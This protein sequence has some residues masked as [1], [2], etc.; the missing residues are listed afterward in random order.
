MWKWSLLFAL[1]AVLSVVVGTPFALN[2][3]VTVVLV[4]L[5]LAVALAAVGRPDPVEHR[6]GRL[7]RRGV[8]Q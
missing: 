3:A 5:S 1:L 4:V 2:P 8:Q 6:P 7:A